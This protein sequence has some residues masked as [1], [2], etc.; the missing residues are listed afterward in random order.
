[1]D[2]AGYLDPRPGDADV[3]LW[4]IPGQRL[5][6][7]PVNLQAT[8]QEA[9]DVLRASSAEALYVER[10]TAPGIRRIYGILT[11]DMVES[12]YLLGI[13]TSCPRQAHF[14]VRAPAHYRDQDQ[15]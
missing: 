10:I 6:V 4:R 14:H 3:D 7:A 5:D 11:R 12:A 13:E 8:L 1:M 15:Q 2:L 9:V